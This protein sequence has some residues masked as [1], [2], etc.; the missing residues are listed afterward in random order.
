MSALLCN[1]AV[2]L[3]KVKG[4]AKDKHVASEEVLAIDKFGNDHA[5]TLAV[6]GSELHAAPEHL[7]AAF[8]R[9]RQLGAATH[10]MMVRILSARKKMEAALGSSHPDE[11]E[12]D[13]EDPWSVDDDMY[14]P[15]PRSGE[16]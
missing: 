4:H 8:K 9:R 3:V 11:Q 2:V 6:E 16:G 1:A 10:T 15:H 13:S 5:D 14:V 12:C 7:V